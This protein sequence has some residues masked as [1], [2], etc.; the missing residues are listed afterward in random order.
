MAG[1]T[2][3]REPPPTTYELRKTLAMHASHGLSA[4][5]DELLLID[6]GGDMPFM[7]ALFPLYF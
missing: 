1:I 7:R 5:A 4:R 3:K 6:A 2:L